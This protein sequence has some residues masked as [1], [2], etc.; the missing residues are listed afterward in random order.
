MAYNKDLLVY[1]FEQTVLRIRKYSFF[2][3]YIC[4]FKFGAKVLKLYDADTQLKM[5]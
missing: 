4:C 1:C 2:H 5:I 3:G